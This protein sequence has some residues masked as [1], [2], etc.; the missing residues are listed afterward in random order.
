MGRAERHPAGGILDAARELVLGEGLRAATVDRIVVASGAPKGSVYHRFGTLDDLLAT[1]WL[2]AVRASQ[3]RFLA[4][5]EE[6]RDAVDDGVAAAMSVYDFA[7]EERDDAALLVVVRAQDVGR[8][9]RDEALARELA[10]VNAPLERAVTDL[11]ARLHGRASSAAVEQAVLAVVDL[12]LGAVRRHLLARR[13]PPLE[14]R[15]PLARAV[16]AALTP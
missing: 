3:A 7:R 14:L 5:L 15:D 12:P 16:R 9:G 6:G 11:A 8:H 2:R 4:A 13:P 1:M 10:T